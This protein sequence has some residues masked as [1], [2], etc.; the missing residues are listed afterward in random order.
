MDVKMFF[1]MELVLEA[2]DSG[3]MLVI[4]A[5]TLGEV[6]GKCSLQLPTPQAAD[7]IDPSGQSHLRG[8]DPADQRS[9]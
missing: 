7:G 5:A 1:R 4:M 2:K 6:T 9:K 8:R 3:M